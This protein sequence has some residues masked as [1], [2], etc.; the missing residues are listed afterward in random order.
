[1]NTE[2]VA[3]MTQ[4]LR[5]QFVETAFDKPGMDE[6]VQMYAVLALTKGVT[7]TNRDVHHAWVIWARRH[8]PANPDIVLYDQLP[9]SMQNEDSPF[10]RAIHAVARDIKTPLV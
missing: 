1:M 7:V 4:L 2:D 5:A 9:R 6:L 3:R 8:D 10:V